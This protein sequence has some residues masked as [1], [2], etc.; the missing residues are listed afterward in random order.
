[1]E[2]KIKDEQTILNFDLVLQEPATL[3]FVNL[4]HL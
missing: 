2:V 1:M 3:I 4:F